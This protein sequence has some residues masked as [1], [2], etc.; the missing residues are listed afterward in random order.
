MEAVG[1]GGGGTV[2]IG[3]GDGGFVVVRHST[4]YGGRAC[5]VVRSRGLTTGL[6]EGE[7]GG[8][9]GQL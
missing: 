5:S 1:F 2:G 3:D 7:E 4:C 8:R 9:E 6:E